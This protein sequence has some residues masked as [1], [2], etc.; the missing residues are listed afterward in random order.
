MLLNFTKQGPGICFS[1]VIPLFYRCHHFV[2]LLYI[3]PANSDGSY[4]R[5][6]TQNASPIGENSSYAE[7]S[8]ESAQKKISVA[9]ALIQSILAESMDVHGFDRK[10][11]Q[12]YDEFND[13]C[14]EHLPGKVK[15]R[16][17]RV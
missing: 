12:F 1:G 5:P 3:I 9:G 15:P 6:Y 8:I 10:T 13:S 16:F 11:I 2:K 14:C 7:G 17:K 4:Q